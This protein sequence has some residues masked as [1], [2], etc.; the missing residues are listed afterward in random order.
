MPPGDY[1]KCRPHE[2]HMTVA[3]HFTGMH[4]VPEGTT[5][6][7]VKVWYRGDEYL[8][9]EEQRQINWDA[10][11]REREAHMLTIAEREKAKEALA[12][13]QADVARL[14][15]G[16]EKM[17]ATVDRLEGAVTSLLTDLRSAETTHAT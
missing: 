4:Y 12:L 16:W 7:R 14:T 6:D 11:V 1:Q 15:G 5:C 8:K 2:P 10:F 13:A 9:A 17:S 3:G